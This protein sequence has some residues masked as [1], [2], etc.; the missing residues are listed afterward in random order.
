MDRLGLIKI[1][2][3]QIP[4]GPN[5]FLNDV[6]SLDGDEPDGGGND[7]P[8]RQRSESGQDGDLIP[9]AGE[10]VCQRARD[11]GSGGAGELNGERRRNDQ[12]KES[13]GYRSTRITHQGANAGSENRTDRPGESRGK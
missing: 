6:A 10:D 11:P 5:F 8:R 1:G 12:Q 9:N 4:A 2:D 3:E 7:R 13:P